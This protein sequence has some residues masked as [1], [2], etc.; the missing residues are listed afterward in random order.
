MALLRI[1]IYP[2]KRLRVWLTVGIQIDR[3]SRNGR[4]NRRE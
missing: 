2:R 3:K 1:G 4:T